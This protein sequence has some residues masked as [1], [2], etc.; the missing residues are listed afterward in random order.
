MPAF[1]IARKSLIAVVIGKVANSQR[2]I[3]RLSY[4]L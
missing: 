2:M 4:A 1:L 3:D